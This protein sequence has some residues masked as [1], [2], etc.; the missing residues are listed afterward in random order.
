MT[1]DNQLDIDGIMRTGSIV[2]SVRDAMLRALEPG[3][4]TRELDGIG[5]RLLHEAGARSAPII[6]YD[7]PGATCISVNEEAAHGIPGDRVI[8]A[9]DVV[10]VDVSAEFEGYYADTGGTRVVPPSTAEKDRL[11]AATRSA[12][13]RAVDVARAGTPIRQIGAT[14]EAVAL[15][16]G[17]ATIRNLA[18][19]GVGRSLHEEP[20]GIV[21]FE[22]P[23]DARVL[24]NGQVIAIEPFLSTSSTFA[25]E[26]ADG[27]TLLCN[28]RNFSAQFEH[29]IIVTRGEPIV[30]TLG[31]F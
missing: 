19:H 31:T 6:S 25:R 10:N 27:W 5:A 16:H 3:M 7:F 28:P 13:D 20:D 9:G 24:R 8:A 1:V 30:A 11:C 12:L 2:A 22:N 21:S 4:T 23:G 14:I 15:S 18:G 26:A 29:T 17:F